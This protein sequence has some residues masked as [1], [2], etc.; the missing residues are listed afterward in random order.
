MVCMLLS[1]IVKK[2]TP[3]ISMLIGIVFVIGCLFSII[4][5]C[6]YLR[7]QLSALSRITQAYSEYF[8]PMYKCCGITIITQLC[9]GLCKDAGQNAVAVAF[10]LMGVFMCLI[11]TVPLIDQIICILGELL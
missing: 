8:E 11:C 9:C 1:I 5:L 6:F 7:S 10:E 3:E 2:H 4:E